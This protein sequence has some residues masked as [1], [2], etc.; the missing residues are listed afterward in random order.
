M[1]NPSR[2]LFNFRSMSDLEPSSSTAQSPKRKFSFRFPLGYTS[3]QSSNSVD[4]HGMRSNEG[5]P[6]PNETTASS[7][8]VGTTLD[9]KHFSEKLKQVTDL[10]VSC[11]H[12]TSLDRRD[13]IRLYNNHTHNTTSINT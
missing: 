5:S 11:H 2:N 7:I 13:L 4:N 10:Q 1:I 12:S 6:K 9:R 8:G 3:G